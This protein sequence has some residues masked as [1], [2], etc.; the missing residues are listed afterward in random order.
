M[1]KNEW[2]INK[3]HSMLLD[4]SRNTLSSSTSWKRIALPMLL[5]STLAMA[6]KAIG[7]GGDF[8]NTDFTAAAPFTYNHQTG[9]GA[10]NDRTVGDYA[11]VTEQ[12][13]GGQFTCGDIVTF[14]S[15][16]QVEDNPVDALQ[17]I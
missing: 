2:T 9:G 14:L 15:Q 1:S 7:A 4:D 8:S 3:H 12:L 10:Y 17:S 11:D 6:P 13:E 5:M 16:V